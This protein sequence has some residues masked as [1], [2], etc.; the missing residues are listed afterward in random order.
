M[1]I[2]TTFSLA[3]LF[4]LACPSTAQNWTGA[5][6][7][8][9]NNPGNWDQWPLDGEDI[10]IDPLAYSGAQ[11]SPL[12][13]SASVFTPDRMYV[14]NGALLAIAA[15]LSVDN[16]LI[17]S[18]GA[19]ATMTAGTLTTD[20]LI[21][22]TGGQFTLNNGTV[23][24]L[25]VLA[26]GDDG[27]AP[28]R[29]VQNGGTVNATGEFGFDCEVG[30]SFPRYE[31]NGGS[32]N[33]NGDV[34]WFGATPGGGR[35]RIVLNSGNVQVDGSLV[36]TTGSTVD[37]HVEIHGGTFTTNGPGIDMAHASDSIVQ[38]GGAF[39]VDDDM[40]FSN[41][42]VFLATG[43]A[44]SF[45][46]QAELRGTGSYRFQHISIAPGA[47]LQ[48]TDPA[49][50]AVAGDWINLGT[51][52]P[53][54]NTVAF[55]G[56]ALQ[57]VSSTGFH[58]LRVDNTGGGASLSGPSTVAGP[59]TL[60]NGLLHTGSND[61]LTLLHGSS[62]T[63]GSATS[64][65]DGPMRK[66]GNDAFVFPVGKAGQW[67]RIGISSINDQDTEF[68]AEFFDSPYT[69]TTSIGPGLVSVNAIEHWSL[70][71]AGTTDDARVEL[72]WE[73]AAASG[74]TDCATLVVSAW[75]GTSWQGAL[76][77]PSGSCTGN[78]PGALISN[79][80]VE[81]Y[82]VL[83]FG[84]NDGT[85]GVNEIVST[86][87]SISFNGNAIQVR[88]NTAQADLTLLDASGKAVLS[89]PVTGDGSFSLPTLPSGWYSAVL[90]PRSGHLPA[91]TF[92]VVLW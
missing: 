29:I 7:S 30:V 13:G 34:L 22:E 89:E 6:N 72:F 79:N 44:V 47:L 92:I 32:L 67:R 68:T 10:T 75:D 11:T 76:S 59:L 23:N 38:T 31:M 56:S 35:G 1:R 25:S 60:D 73:D 24:T 90:A 16:R 39:H 55:V 53:D 27:T 77:T 51:F 69:N 87:P 80:A 50:I 37:L 49:E 57:T 70:A 45:D 58:G 3:I 78:D 66:V 8:D 21:A 71:R 65:V 18:D 74:I 15:N 88:G 12:I 48:H 4:A 40:V 17:V 85:I 14:Q 86:A 20:R 36:N 19:E 26:L 42:G 91:R 41:D 52:D 64:H 62:S 61:L 43:G 82:D 83:T 28:S 84:S 5:I 81:Y 9:W 63:T 54:V 2:R 33:V 46:Q